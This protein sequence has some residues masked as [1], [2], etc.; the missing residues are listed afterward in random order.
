VHAWRAVLAASCAAQSIS[1]SAWHAVDF[2]PKPAG[3][4]CRTAALLHFAVQ[5][6]VKVLELPRYV[7]ARCLH[8]GERSAT[9]FQESGEV[10]SRVCADG[11]NGVTREDAAYQ[12]FRL[13]RPCTPT[14]PVD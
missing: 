8:D 2:R 10:F 12:A 3:F 6:A 9:L 4:L 13:G 14:Q 5:G 1:T 11:P 7:H